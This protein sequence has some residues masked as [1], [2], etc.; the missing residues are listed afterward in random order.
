MDD[1]VGLDWI[2]SL[3]NMAFES[4][5]CLNTGGIPL[6][7]GKGERTEC[8]NYRGIIMLSMVGKIY[9]RILV[10]EFVE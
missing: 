9:P 4:V 6:F 3:C 1:D 7:K 5:L 2:L 10:D 8:R